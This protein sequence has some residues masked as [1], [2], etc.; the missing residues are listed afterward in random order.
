MM[1]RGGAWSGWPPERC[2]SWAGLPTRA[3]DSGG[4][5]TDRE[6]GVSSGSIA[7]TWADPLGGVSDKEMAP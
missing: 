6:A 2:S 4:A 7:Q 3:W 1:P 5:P